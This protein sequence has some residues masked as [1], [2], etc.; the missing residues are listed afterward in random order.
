MDVI[1][2][3]GGLVERVDALLRLNRIG[4]LSVVPF[5]LGNGD[6]FEKAARR[7]PGLRPWFISLP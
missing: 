4:D 5:E 3:A 1:E 6:A 2:I 7:R